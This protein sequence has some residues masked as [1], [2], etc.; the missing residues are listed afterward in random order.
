[1]MHKQALF[2]DL[3]PSSVKAFPLRCSDGPKATNYWINTPDPGQGREGCSEPQRERKGLEQGIEARDVPYLP[4]FLFQKC[5]LYLGS[6]SVLIPHN[7]QF[8]SCYL[9]LNLLTILGYM[10]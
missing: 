7:L 8:L 5:L 3:A 2:F 6:E 4:A 10:V 9:A 1:M